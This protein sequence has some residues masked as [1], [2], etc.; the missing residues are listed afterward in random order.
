MKS[1]VTTT[2]AG[3]SGSLEVVQ[4]AKRKPRVPERL[5]YGLI[6]LAILLPAWEIV[7]RL[8][9]V[10]SVLISSPSAIAVAAW[11]VFSTGEIWPDI[12]ASAQSF[13]IGLGLAIVIGI[14]IGILLGLFRPLE[15]LLYPLL[16]GIYSTPKVAIIPLIIVIAGIGLAQQATVVFLS[17]VFTLIIATTQG[18]QATDTRHIEVARY[19]GA[20]RWLRLRSVVLPTTVPFIATGLRIATGRALVGIVV[21]EFIASNVGIGYF[22]SFN[23]AFLK[24]DRVFVG[25][26]LLGVLGMVMGELVRRFEQRFERWR[27]VVIN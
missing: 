9:L 8:G 18:V 19:F 16:Y 20:S 4:P 5:L 15:H 3:A 26:L 25:L 23:G 11:E 6:G 24:T 12:G 14:P 7:A 27:P 21:A 1:R 22:I 17:C 10:K 13:A 2:P